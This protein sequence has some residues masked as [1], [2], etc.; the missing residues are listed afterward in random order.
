[1]TRWPAEIP[2]ELLQECP[3]VPPLTGGTGA[4]VLQKLVDLASEYQACRARL[5]SLITL[6]KA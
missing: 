4:D 1:M 5:R 2:P 6:F 3:A